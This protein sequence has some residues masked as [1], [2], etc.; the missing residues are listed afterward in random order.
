MPTPILMGIH[1]HPGRQHLAGRG[2]GVVWACIPAT[3]LG[4]STRVTTGLS[5]HFSP[6]VKHSALTHGNKVVLGQPPTPSPVWSCILKVSFHHLLPFNKPTPSH[7]QWVG[8]P[9]LRQCSGWRQKPMVSPAPGPA[10]PSW[11]Y[12]R[13]APKQRCFK[14]GGHLNRHVSIS[15]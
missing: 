12:L 1:P 8:G 7:C 4:H 15:F 10:S 14:G 3:V 11:P 9:D 6:N 2:W 13:A 5:A